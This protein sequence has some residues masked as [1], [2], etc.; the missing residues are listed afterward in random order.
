[1]ST[2]ASVS[3]AYV[4]FVNDTFKAGGRVAMLPIQFIRKH[5]TALA[6][7]V[8]VALAAFIFVMD[9]LASQEATAADASMGEIPSPADYAAAV[10]K[11]GLGEACGY[12]MFCRWAGLTSIPTPTIGFS[13][14]ALIG[15]VFPLWFTGIFM[16]IAAMIMILVGFLLVLAGWFDFSS[17]FLLRGDHIF[18]SIAKNM[19]LQGDDSPESTGIKFIVFAVLG[20][21]TAWYIWALLIKNRAKEMFIRRELLIS[22][23]FILLIMVM[24]SQAAKNHA[25]LTDDPASLSTMGQTSSLGQNFFEQRLGV[26]NASDPANWATFSPGWFVSLGQVGI[27]WMGNLSIGVVSD[28]G[29]SLK[30]DTKNQAMMGGDNACGAYTQ[31]MHSIFRET[32]Y[33]KSSAGYSNT[34]VQ[35]DDFVK[36]IY[37]D[38]Y[39]VMTLGNSDSSANSW[40][41]IADIAGNRA[42]GDQAFVARE[43]GLYREAVGAGSL[44]PG[45]ENTAVNQNGKRVN[46]E[47]TEINSAWV[48]QDGTWWGE[49]T[50]IGDVELPQEGAMRAMSVFGPSFP[51]VDSGGKVNEVLSG[52]ANSNSSTKAPYVWAIC[53]SGTNKSLSFN[54]EWQRASYAEPAEDGQWSNEGERRIKCL[55]AWGVNKNTDSSHKV[56]EPGFGWNKAGSNE[57]AYYENV[58]FLG[59]ALFGMGGSSNFKQLGGAPVALDYYVSSVGMSGP[60]QTL[61]GGLVTLALVL[62]TGKTL[63][64]L[65]FAGFIGGQVANFAL[66]FSFL[67]MFLLVLPWKKARKF[68]AG[69]YMSIITGLLVFMVIGVILSMILLTCDLFMN[70]FSGVL[71]T[72]IM[73][74][75][76]FTILVKALLLVAAV[77]TWH[78]FLKKFNLT[79]AE[80]LMAITG[81]TIAPLANA[82][83]YRGDNLRKP[84]DSDFVGKFYKGNNPFN[85]TTDQATV[86]G[87]KKGTVGTSSANGSNSDGIFK[88][89]AKKGVG[90]LGKK[91][92]LANPIAGAGIVAAT[93]GRDALKRIKGLASSPFPMQDKVTGAKAALADL[94]RSGVQNPFSR[95]EAGQY[96]YNGRELKNPALLDILK[97]LDIPVTDQAPKDG[98][99]TDRDAANLSPF[100][101]DKPSVAN[102]MLP[103]PAAPKN[104]LADNSVT[105]YNTVPPKVTDAEGKEQLFGITPAGDNVGKQKPA[106]VQDQFSQHRAQALEGAKVD[107]KTTPFE[108]AE[109]AASMSRN[110]PEQDLAQGRA[111]EEMSKA[112]GAAPNEQY[113]GALGGF[114]AKDLNIPVERVSQEDASKITQSLASDGS[115]RDRDLEKL[116][117]M[118]GLAYVGTRA[119]GAGDQERNNVPLV[120][121]D[122]NPMGATRRN[123]EPFD[124]ASFQAPAG[125]EYV[126]DH[127]APEV[128][129]Q[130]R[131][132]RLTPEQITVLNTTPSGEPRNLALPESSRAMESIADQFQRASQLTTEQIASLNSNLLPTGEPK[133]EKQFSEDRL[134]AALGSSVIPVSV[135]MGKHFD[136]I[137]SEMNRSG[138]QH[139]PALDDAIRTIMERGTVSAADFEGLAAMINDQRLSMGEAFQRSLDLRDTDLAQ[140][141]SNMSPEDR[142]AFAQR[143]EGWTTSSL[144]AQNM[145][146]SAYVEAIRNAAYDGVYSGTQNLGHSIS[147]DLEM[148]RRAI[149]EQSGLMGVHNAEQLR[150]SAFSTE[151]AMRNAMHISRNMDGN[152]VSMN[153][154]SSDANEALNRLVSHASSME[155][156]GDQVQEPS[157]HSEDAIIRRLTDIINRPMSLFRR[158]QSGGNAS[159][160]GGESASE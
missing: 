117:G 28:I 144:G 131:A 10:P 160:G 53:L 106:W 119:L 94:Q 137:S 86:T 120:T 75:G 134:A 100:V 72:T 13:N 98:L 40:C 67:L 46:M 150:A 2:F 70:M 15:A 23:G 110:T 121:D 22:V 140:A 57:F 108:R 66:V 159:Q 11:A 157:H 95:N 155:S 62:Y 102:A 33:A 9:P 47:A 99:V 43:A 149:Q 77:A 79:N 126:Q 90:A 93:K 29:Q 7:L 68:V 135:D 114:I 138:S 73:G 3:D 76:M 41:R 142:G 48:N 52:D 12:L 45:K 107:D 8:L 34:I 78:H 26:E 148:V 27:S 82:M 25:D 152:T 85:R 136:A 146:Q 4:D 129:E 151:E 123:E 74:M 37:F 88:T 128:S 51:N 109:A 56:P 60:G 133:P 115:I 153:G 104:A 92:A 125:A 30:P 24:G 58:G 1:M 80:G 63:G 156:Q 55:E 130:S 42:P 158:N 59:G 91:V 49:K 118:G 141:L 96:F 101:Q 139:A 116:L 71:D 17:L 87:D 35:Y 44:L 61:V 143:V 147:S 122:Q 19:M 16:S 20:L 112:R 18:G 65:T 39:R 81:S 83:G 6:A 124:Q 105:T 50:K 111:A 64:G 132:A 113:L 36:Q 54:G 69:M 145:D 5:K 38:N 154:F 127:R 103:S 84:W 14:I 89:A 97:Q 31:A 32:N 21:M